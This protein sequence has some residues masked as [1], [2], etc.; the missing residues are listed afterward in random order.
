M[1]L[2]TCS[3]SC[4]GLQRY[5][6]RQSY[7]FTSLKKQQL[8]KMSFCLKE[9]SF[10]V[11]LAIIAPHAIAS[12][13][14]SPS[15]RPQY[16]YPVYDVR[17]CPVQE[18]M[19]SGANVPIR[20]LEVLPGHGFDNLR[21]LV[22]GQVHLYNYS[23]CKV[24]EDGKYM[25]P[26]SVF[27]VPLQEGHYKFFAD[28][29][30][31]WDNYTSIVNSQVNVK[32]DGLFS[33]SGSYS[34]EKQSV[35]QNQVNF[36]SKTTRITFRNRVYSVHLDPA[37]ELH[38]KFKSKIYEISA[39]VQNNDSSLGRYLSEILVRD[40]GTH[41]VTSAVA[42]AVFVQLDSIS[43]TYARNVDRT[44][45]TSSASASFPLFQLLGGG[46]FSLGYNRNV[47]Q[48]SIEAYQTSLKRSEIFTIGGA[49]FTPDLNLTRWVNDVPNRLATIDRRADPIHF[50]V[51]TTHFPELPIPTIRAVADYLLEATDRYYRV[52]T[53][54]GCVDPQA[55]NFDFQANF[56]DST[57]CNTTFAHVNRV[58]GGIYQNCR[59]N[60]EAREDL[61]AD[62]EISQVN[63]QTGDFTCP[64][65]YT[66]VSLYN[67][68]DSYTGSYTTYY[69][70]CGFWGC[71][72]RSRSITVTTIAYYETFWCVVL[73][74]PQQYRGYL[75]GGYFTPTDANIVTGTQSCPPYYRIQKIAV[76]ISICVSND[77]ELG[78]PHALGF[79]GFHSCMVGN[80]LSIPVGSS[81]VFPPV[82]NWP[83]SCPGGYSQH[84]VAVQDGCEITVCLE[85]GAFRP[86]SL[87]P[88]RLPPFQT[89]PPYM[90]Y[91]TEKLTIIGSNGGILVRN[92]V[93][94]WRWF[95]RETEEAMS[96]YE[97]LQNNGTSPETNNPPSSFGG[98]NTTN[99]SSSPLVDM[100]TIES[101]TVTTELKTYISLAMSTVAI[102]SV[103]ILAFG[104]LTCKCVKCS[105]KRRKHFTDDEAGNRLSVRLNENAN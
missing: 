44:T 91:T 96:Y 68:T 61:C 50:A 45:V 38:P 71:D 95:S 28:Y 72:T 37:S 30:D 85:N 57:Y 2:L 51:T 63:P 13:D 76:D 93:G 23:T 75:F 94:Q 59:H 53:R 43:E 47:T 29:F 12:S 24:T 8:V 58:F 25:I 17:N 77:Y 89:K 97:L 11:F 78:F 101:P 56:G 9:L 16:V 54:A 67:G 3:Y 79:A 82:A 66:P 18:Q 84:L 86:K 70:T 87:L 88:P 98:Q 46:S 81:N 80:P 21:N 20:R 41:F 10:V 48:I 99:T 90:P 73:N 92:T 62:R 26:D 35:K 103:I 34:R 40:Y 1:N 33:I 60:P 55:Q 4:S 52:N 65:G 104:L 74:T 19:V 5:K 31:H 49:A 32:F 102:A 64:T 27:V 14:P 83:H 42:G 36:N 6:G 15:E 105:G 69:R 100:S 22:M 7:I 39:A